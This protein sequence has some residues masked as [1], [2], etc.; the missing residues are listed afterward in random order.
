MS[1]YIDRKYINLVSPQLE[2]FAWKSDTLANCRCPICGDSQKNKRKARG[3][4]YLK[5]NDYFYK[6]HNCG[7]GH[8]LYRFLES[9]CGSLSKEYSL[10]RWKNGENGRSNYIKPKEKNMFTFPQPKFKANC[11]LLKPLTSVKKLDDDHVCKQFVKMRNIPKKFH[12]VLYYTD[13]FTS[14]MRMVDPDLPK[15]EW[16][17]R[18]PRLIIPFFNKKGDVVAVQGRSLSLKD[19]ANARQTLRYITVKA[20]KSIERLW[21]GMWRANP[22]KR[23]YVV[24][25]PIDSMFV[26]NTV[27][28]VGASAMEQV[29][30][31]FA[32]TDM[33]YALDNEPRNLQIIRYNEKLISEGKTVC[34]W[35]TNLVEKDINDMIYRMTPK[36]IKKIMDDNAVSGMEATLKLKE[37]RRA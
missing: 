27:A 12:D 9:V 18:E 2:R 36:E 28:M 21:Y 23:V 1:S 17:Y 20:D 14:Y 15:R 32:N 19:E 8:S 16:T 30:A 10:E 24:E 13:N 7:A 6:C 3:F 29:P 34:I 37:W 33:V 11:D 5:G 22:K 31:R 4:F 25:G 26:P 35:P